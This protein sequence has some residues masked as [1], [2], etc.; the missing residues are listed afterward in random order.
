MQFLKNDKV[1]HTYLSLSAVIINY[2]NYQL[3]LL[4][5]LL[6][7]LFYALVLNSQALIHWKQQCN[8][9]TCFNVLAGNE[10]ALK[11]DRVSP[12]ECHRQLL[13]QVDGCLL[14]TS[15]AADE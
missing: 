3:L 9:I 14:Y 5:L 15:D 7:L 4:L 2:I 13:E 8:I 1:A 6:L 10:H 12:L 11:G